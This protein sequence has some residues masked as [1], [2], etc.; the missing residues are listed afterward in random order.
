M[1]N[2]VT[3]V[4]NE[5]R[6]FYMQ[7]NSLIKGCILVG[8]S[9]QT[10]KG[11]SVYELYK[12]VTLQLLI[13]RETNIIKR[14]HFNLVSPLTQEVLEEIVTGYD[15]TESIDP[16]LNQI[17]ADVALSSTGAVVQALK[18]AYE[19]YKDVKDKSR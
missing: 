1:C 5:K 16:L 19:R 4:A 17:R 18:N 12:T 15:L 13:D 10:T 11:S 6:G 3:I 7:E 9:A 14:C 2:P 8:G